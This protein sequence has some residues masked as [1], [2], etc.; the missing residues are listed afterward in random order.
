MKVNAK[1]IPEEK[2]QKQKVNIK[3]IHGLFKDQ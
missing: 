1:D 3:R 2:P